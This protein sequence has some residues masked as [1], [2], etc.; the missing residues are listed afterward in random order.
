MKRISPLI[1]QEGKLEVLLDGVLKESLTL[2][3]RKNGQ[4]KYLIKEDKKSRLVQ[5]KKISE[6]RFDH[7]S[8][9]RNYVEMMAKEEYSVPWYTLTSKYLFSW[10]IPSVKVN[11]LNNRKTLDRDVNKALNNIQIL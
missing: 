8:Q 7:P 3:R 4:I 1:R 6:I 5:S 11:Y 10:Q 9:A 2:L